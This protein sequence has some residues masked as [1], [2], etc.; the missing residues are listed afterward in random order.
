MSNRCLVLKKHKNYKT[1]PWKNGLGLTSEVEIFP[2]GSDFSKSDFL[3]RLSSAKI[4]ESSSFS[5]FPGYDR[6]LV[7]IQGQGVLLNGNHLAPLVPFFFQ[8]ETSIKCELVAE[9][10]LDL[11]LLFK[12]GEVSAKMSV[13]TSSSELIFTKQLTFIFCIQGSFAFQGELSAPAAVVAAMAAEQVEAMDC[14]KVSEPCQ[15]QIQPSEDLIYVRIEIQ[16]I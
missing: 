2:E 15:L 5:S 11:G 4:R 9:E 1:S 3:W 8:G 13:E 6:L 10:V 12:R 16:K 7:L 14:L